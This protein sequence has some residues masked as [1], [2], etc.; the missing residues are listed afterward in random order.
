[1]ELLIH[2]TTDFEI[3]GKGD[4][5]AWSSC[6]WISLT[7]FGGSATFATKIKALYSSKGVYFLFDCEDQKLTS[8][9]LEDGGALFD[10]DVV[11]LF[12]QPDESQRLYLEYEVS[13][14]DKQLLL[15]VPND[16]RHFFGW[17]P[18][19][20][21]EADRLPRHA[22]SIRGG[23]R[24]PHAKVTGWSAEIFVPYLLMI[25]LGNVPP[26]KDTVWRGNFYRIDYDEKPRTYF[27]WC[28][29][30]GRIFH[31]F[32]HFGWLRFA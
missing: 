21:L 12:L 17:V 4:A 23:T 9:I 26:K 32:K 16:G 11:E 31:D 15:L 19:P 29:D 22:T 5:A 3:T 13:P 24:E 20:H 1:M 18:Q 2:P 28:R 25:G 10:E 14:L 6:E 8:T 27:S 7:P 30:T